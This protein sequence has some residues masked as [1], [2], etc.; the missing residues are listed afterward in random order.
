MTVWKP[1]KRDISISECSENGIIKWE[2]WKCSEIYGIQSIM[3]QEEWHE[4]ISKSCLYSVCSYFSYLR[5]VSAS[6]RWFYYFLVVRTRVEY[7]EVTMLL[8]QSSC[9]QIF[10]SVY[11]NFHRKKF[12]SAVTAVT[13]LRT[14]NYLQTKRLPVTFSD[15]YYHAEF[16][17]R[18]YYRLLLLTAWCTTI[19]GAKGSDTV[20]RHISREINK[21]NT[22][23]HGK[24]SFQL[25]SYKI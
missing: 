22:I 25:P 6:K 2:S 19:P 24:E 13:N 20:C 14:I 5:N 11:V 8:L 16:S 10:S 12:S 23:Q 1:F 3:A 17:K 4:C 21:K 15:F 18:S 7:I 9:T